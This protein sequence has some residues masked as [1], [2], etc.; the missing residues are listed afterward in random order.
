MLALLSTCFLFVA[1]SGAASIVPYRYQE[2]GNRKKGNGR[3]VRDLTHFR[4][5]STV[6]L[7]ATA[8]TI[9]ASVAY[10]FCKWSIW[11]VCLNRELRFERPVGDG[12]GAG[13][14]TYSGNPQ[15]LWSSLYT[16]LSLPTICSDL[17]H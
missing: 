17:A 11:Y 13:S 5:T 14:S 4:P 16:L 3:N 12:C 10:C 8:R 6:I 7:V 2:D 15:I 1:E 9:I